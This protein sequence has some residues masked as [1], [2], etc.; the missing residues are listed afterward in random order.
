[1]CVCVCVCVCVCLCVSVSVCLCLCLCLCVSV[2]VCVSVFC[3]GV[4]GGS[5]GERG[6]GG[7][8]LIS[9]DNFKF[10]SMS[11]AF[12]TVCRSCSHFNTSPFNINA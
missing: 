11:T 2:C 9:I 5:W 1:M 10:I 4:G 6:G 12:E 3:A 7:Y 8:R